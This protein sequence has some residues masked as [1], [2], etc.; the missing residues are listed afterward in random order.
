MKKR[1]LLLS[2]F[3]A[4]VG[5][6]VAFTSNTDIWNLPGQG[7]YNGKDMVHV[8]SSYN[9]RLYNGN[10]VFG[11]NALTPTTADTQV[12]PSITVGG[13]YGLK[14]PITNGSGI[15]SVK[16]M[17]AVASTT[18]TTAVDGSFV[19]ITATT[20]VIGVVDSAYA[21]GSTMFLTTHGFANV[22]TTGAVKVGDIL[23]SSATAQGRAGAATGTVVVGTVIG[24]ALTVGAAA[25]DT[26]LALIDLQ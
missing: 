24:K 23:V 3:I 18:L 8:D 15:T 13:N 10:L 9:L 7:I 1:I 17:V 6:G 19:S 22:L 14:F 5:L 26:V 25:G 4:L 21:S 11:D 16:G 20:T 2:G 12:T